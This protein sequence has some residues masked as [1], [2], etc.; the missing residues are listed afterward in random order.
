MKYFFAHRLTH[1]K[2]SYL[3]KFPAKDASGKYFL[4]EGSKFKLV[5]STVNKEAEVE[6]QEKVKKDFIMDKKVAK[7]QLK[8]MEV[9]E[10]IYWG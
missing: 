8:P 7:Q 1:Y 4:S 3:V 10:D 5:V 9:Y 2:R 6:W